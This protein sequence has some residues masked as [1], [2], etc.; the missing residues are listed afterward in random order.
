MLAS[1]VSCSERKEN[2]SS[3]AR[4]D[5][6]AVKKFVQEFY[7]GYMPLTTK[8]NS[9]PASDLA[10][11]D[12]PQAFDAQLLGRLKEDSEAQAKAKGDL[13]G[14]DFD[15]FLGSQDPCDR[16]DVVNVTSKEAHYLVDVRGSGG[17]E[18]HDQADVTAEVVSTN[19][20]WQ[21]SNFHYPGPPAYD[22]LT[23]LKK[24]KEDRH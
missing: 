3:E 15:P 19:G 21:F 13:V 16:Y 14:L 18:K 9:G 4:P 2:S 5:T 8:S 6:D 22:L 1:A 20:M 7:D 11:R 24:L 17:C 23:I 12:R 10:L